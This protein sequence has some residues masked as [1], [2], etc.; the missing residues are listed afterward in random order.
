MYVA[1]FDYL[2]AKSTALDRNPIPPIQ[3]EV[4]RTNLGRR[5]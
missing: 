2:Y 4:S 5:N 3:W 1:Y